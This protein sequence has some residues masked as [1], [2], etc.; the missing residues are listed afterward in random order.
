M[1]KLDAQFRDKDIFDNLSF[2]QQFRA[3]NFFLQFLVN[4]LPLDPDPESQNDADP[5]PKHYLRV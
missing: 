5:D 3:K 4:I 1:Q 2:F